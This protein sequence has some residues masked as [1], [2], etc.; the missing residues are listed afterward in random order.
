MK[1]IHFIFFY[2]KIIFRYLYIFGFFLAY[3]FYYLGLEKCYDGFDLCSIKTNWIYKKICEVIISCFIIVL[4]IELIFYKIISPINLLHC[5][6]FYIISFIYS[7]GYDFEDHGYYNFW[8]S[9]AII[10]LLL[11]AISPLN[12]FHIYTEI[13]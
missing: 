6:S 9:I 11:L 3:I 2:L 4:L 8:A 1:I 13:K 12:S 10:I 7:H 5:L